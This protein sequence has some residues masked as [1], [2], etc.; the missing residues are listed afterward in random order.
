VYVTNESEAGKLV[1]GIVA[2]PRTNRCNGQHSRRLRGRREIM[3]IWIRRS[4][5]KCWR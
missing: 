3:E 2:R 4:S 1:E 5:T